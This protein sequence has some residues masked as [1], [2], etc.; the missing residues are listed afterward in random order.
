M[1]NKIS[2]KHKLIRRLS[3]ESD[4]YR[5]EPDYIG[6]IDLDKPVQVG[7]EVSVTLSEG[8]MRRNDTST[9]LTIL[10]IAN[11]DK[12]IFVRKVSFIKEI[13]RSKYHFQSVMSGKYHKYKG[14]FVEFWDENKALFKANHNVRRFISEKE[15]NNLSNEYKRY[16]YRTTEHWSSK[17]TVYAIN[18]RFPWYELVFKVEKSY[19]TKIKIPNSKAKSEYDKLQNKLKYYWGRGL[20]KSLGWTKYDDWYRPNNPK[21]LRKRWKRYCKQ[22]INL[23]VWW[24]EEFD[25]EG[26]PYGYPEM[27][28]IILRQNKL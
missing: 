23:P 25:E 4:K 26:N 15:Y 6:F 14:S 28:G 5:D 3:G 11:Y 10:K 27:E 12:V 16:F 24:S 19:I 1:L 22:A 18:E 13:R 2:K 17:K 9:L 8:G 21:Y 20:E 7:W